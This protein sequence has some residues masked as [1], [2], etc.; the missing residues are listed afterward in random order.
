[1]VN[2]IWVLENIRNSKNFYTSFDTKMLIAS[3]TQWKKHNPNTHTIFYCDKLTYETFQKMELL[4]A[5]D[6]AKVIPPSEDIDKHIF[7]SSCKVEVL[8]GTTKPTVILDNDFIVYKSFE[9]LLKDTVIVG[10]DEDGQDYYPNALDPYVRQT[11]HLLSRPNHK[12]VNC[13]F[14]YFPNPKFVAAYAHTGVELMKELT[15]LKAPN[16]NYLVY[17]EQLLLK[18]LLDLHKQDYDTLVNEV[19]QC[20]E[21]YFVPTTKGLI[22]RKEQ[23]LWFRHYWMDKKK[24]LKDEDGFNLKEEVEQLDNC[25]KNR[26]LGKDKLLKRIDEYFR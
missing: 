2:V 25:I 4:Q 22:D 1:M 12:S 15:R 16:S 21:R 5:W 11:N 6:E 23:K 19:W 13:C 10:H 3:V 18:H 8:R 9:P 7:W 24:I 20:K 17:A 26:I 14:L